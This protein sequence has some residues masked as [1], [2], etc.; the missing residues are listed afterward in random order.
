V[1][2]V[3][4]FINMLRLLWVNPDRH[5]SGTVRMPTQEEAEYVVR[6]AVLIV[7]WLHSGALV[8]AP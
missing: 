6:L 2:G 3:E 8:K 1:G 4:T 7:G 5:A